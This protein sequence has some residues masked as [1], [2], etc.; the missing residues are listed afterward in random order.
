MY[1]YRERYRDIDIEREVIDLDRRPV[2]LERVLGVGEDA[3]LPRRAVVLHVCACVCMYI[4]IYV[5]YVY[6]YI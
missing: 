1:I 5:Y 2:A 4:Y 3:A 6:I